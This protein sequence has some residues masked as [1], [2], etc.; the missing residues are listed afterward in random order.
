MPG[1]NVTRA[2][3][4]K[5]IIKAFGIDSVDTESIEL[6]FDDVNADDWFYEY[7]C[8]AADKGI[9]KGNGNK[10]YPQATITRQEAA[11]MMYRILES[12]ELKFLNEVQLM[13]FDD[14]NMID[15]W[16]F[17]AVSKLQIYGIINGNTDGCFY[18]KSAITRA[19]TAKL[20]YSSYMLTENI[21]E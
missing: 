15:D 7:I 19:E 11:T 12:Q 9:L 6:K 5:M 2:E 14:S 17:P 3:F 16:A 4:V 18:P 13:K 20:I 21:V 10:A 8:I 1:K